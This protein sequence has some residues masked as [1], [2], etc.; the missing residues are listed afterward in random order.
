MKKNIA[1]PEWRTGQSKPNRIANLTTS[2]FLICTKKR[3]AKRRKRTAI[4]AIARLEYE[5]K[6]LSEEL[7]EELD[8]LKMIHTKKSEP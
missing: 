7:S 8:K 6:K 2:L 4:K 3:A 1:A 5:E